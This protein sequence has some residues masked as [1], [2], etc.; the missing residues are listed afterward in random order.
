MPS[1]FGTLARVPLFASL[2]LD[3]VRALDARCLWRR[4]GGGDWVVD[5]QSEGRDV[6]FVVSG[7]V[8]VVAGSSGRATILGDLRDGQHFGEVAAIDGSPGMVGLRAVADSVV[9]RMSPAVFLEAVHRHPSVRDGLL[10]TL[11]HVVRFLA[12]RADEHAHLRVRERLSAELLRLSRA[13]AVGRVV[14]SP[15]PTHAE[16]AAR[17]GTNREAVTRSLK[18]LQLEGAIARTRSAIVIVDPDL[19]RGL[20]GEGK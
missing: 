7:H 13:S 8:H 16:L 14:V 18:A 6:Y 11:A 4:V 20:A 1:N 9:A 10:A 15:P 12:N 5:E 17:I 2:E 19:L 3:D